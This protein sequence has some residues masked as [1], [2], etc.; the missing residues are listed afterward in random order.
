VPRPRFLAPLLTLATLVE[1]G[2]A[3]GLSNLAVVDAGGFVSEFRAFN[4]PPG[5]YY[6]R[7]R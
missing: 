3:P 5:A 6:V 2:S 7:V 1:A 4:V